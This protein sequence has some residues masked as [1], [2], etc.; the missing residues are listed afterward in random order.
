[1]TMSALLLGFVV[2]FVLVFAGGCCLMVVRTLGNAKRPDDSRW[3]HAHA[4]QRRY[5]R[6]LPHRIRRTM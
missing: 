1:M 2:L 4:H 5:R 3:R 6:F